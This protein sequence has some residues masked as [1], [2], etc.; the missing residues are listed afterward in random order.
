MSDRNDSDEEVVER[1][2]WYHQVLTDREKA[3]LRGQVFRDRV[4]DG[5]DLSKADLSF[6][7]LIDCSLIGG[8]LQHADLRHARFRRCDLRWSAFD[9]ARLGKNRL[10]G[11]VLGGASGLGRDDVGSARRHGAS[12]KLDAPGRGRDD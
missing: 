10:E 2:P 6:A 8:N 9:G 3:E 5:F 12:F 11:S 4:F 7:K 1:V